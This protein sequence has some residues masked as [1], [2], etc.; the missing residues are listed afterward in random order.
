LRKPGALKAF[1]APG[2]ATG[3]PFGPAKTEADVGVRPQSFR[4]KRLCHFSASDAG[5][6]P[7]D[8]LGAFSN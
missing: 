6:I 5:E 8:R 2:E 1:L 4:C 3:S 7:E